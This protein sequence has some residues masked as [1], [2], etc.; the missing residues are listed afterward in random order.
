MNMN[1]TDKEIFAEDKQSY[2]PVFNRYQI[3]LDHGEG[4]YEWQEI[5]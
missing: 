3:V 1:E 4:A 2:L 5:H